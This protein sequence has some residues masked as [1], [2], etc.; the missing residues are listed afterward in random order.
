MYQPKFSSDARMVKIDDIELN[1][2]YIFLEHDYIDISTLL[3]WLEDE[4]QDWIGTNICFLQKEDGDIVLAAEG[5]Y[6]YKYAFRTKRE[7]FVDMMKQWH[8]IMFTKK[9][10]MPDEITITLY[11][12][13]KVAIMPKD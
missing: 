7:Y 1:R 5:D 11:E 13:G 10:V 9:E 2:I 12:D 6:E 4:S 3:E 8:E